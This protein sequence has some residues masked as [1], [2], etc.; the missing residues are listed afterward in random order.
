MKKLIKSSGVKSAGKDVFEARSGYKLTLEDNVW[1]LDKNVSINVYKLRGFLSE[2]M[3]ESVL[4]V[5]KFYAK[6]RAPLHVFNLFNRLLHWLN[7]LDVRL[8][9]VN[10]HFLINYRSSLDREHEWYLGTIKGFLKKWHELG[11]EGVSDDVVDLL[12]SWRLKG[13]VK[14]DV[15]KRLDPEQ[16]PLTDIEL[17]NIIEAAASLYEEDKI[18]IDQF[19][20]VRLL[21]ASGRRP[22]QLS[23]MKL[24][25]VM[26]G[27]NKNQGVAYV[28]NI[29]RAKQR[30][31]GF[32]GSFKQLQVTENLWR[33]LD[34][35]RSNVISR[36]E[37][38]FGK[39]NDK[40]LLELPLF[41][42]YKAIQSYDTLPELAEILHLDILHCER[43]ALSKAAEAVIK[44]AEVM[45]ERTG[46]LINI[47]AQRFRY[48]VGTRA[49]REGYGALIIA[50]LLDHTDTQN[51]QV[52]VQNVPEYARKIN[53]KVGHLLVPYANAFRGIIVDNEG[54]A[55]RGKDPSSRVRLNPHENVGTCGSY[56]FCGSRVPIPCYTCN[57][58]QPWLD[59]PHEKVLQ[60]LVDERER[61]YQQ[62]NDLAI[63]SINDR[64]IVAITEVVSLCRAKREAAKHG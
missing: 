9:A 2:G 23:H 39:L 27:S 56:D 25:D 50:E 6:E 30:G 18:T 13:N 4:S 49:A 40:V 1:V 10:P 43:I 35:Q 5:L 59:A 63:A 58:F 31:V 24:K 52:Y 61:I 64:T 12:N 7:S 34:L 45:S 38:K 54:E 16:G 51:A 62:T 3:L 33:I 22:I 28:L 55:R 47:N 29:P 46:E 57:H 42:D 15:V 60:E 20:M 32:R 37:D 36:F 21:S 11:Y 17:Q 26:H 41:P 19:A 8:E 48:S 44:V 53:D 14:G